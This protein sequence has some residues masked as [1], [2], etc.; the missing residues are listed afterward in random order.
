MRVTTQKGIRHIKNPITRRLKTQRWRNKRVLPGKW[1]SD[2]AKFKVPS[3]MQKEQVAQ[4]FTNGKDYEEFCT[5]LN[6]MPWSPKINCNTFITYY[7][8]RDM[9][10]IIFII[11]I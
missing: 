10:N 2:T 7:I 4:V 9:V 8:D 3:I 5:G 11:V 6:G 1:F